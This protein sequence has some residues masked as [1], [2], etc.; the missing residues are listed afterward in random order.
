MRRILAITPNL[1]LPMLSGDSIRYNNLIVQ[2]ARRGWDVSLFSLCRERDFREAEIRVLRNVYSEI[3]VYPF[4]KAS[5]S[6]YVDLAKD[7]ILRRPFHDHLLWSADAQAIF[8]RSFS[9]HRYDVIFIHLIHMYR[10]VSGRESNVSILDTHSAEYLRL[11][12]MIDGNPRSP[13]AF[14][15]RTQ[16][17]PVKKFE[18]ETVRE[19]ACTL[20][21][22]PDELDYFGSLGARRVEL[23]ANGV[24]LDTHYPKSGVTREPRILFLGSLSYSANLDALQYLIDAILPN[25]KRADAQLDIVG[26]HPPTSLP[27]ISS[28]SPIRADAVGE[29]VDVRPY[30]DRN[31]FLV[32]PLRYGGGTRVKIIEGLAQGIPVIST[33][34]GCSGLGLQHLEEIIVVDDAKEFAD[35]IDRLLEDTELCQRLAANGRKK[36]ERDFGWSRI[37]DNLHVVIESIASGRN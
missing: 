8:D 33:S 14:Y 6:K 13:R 16:L 21:V 22:S 30:I 9:L 7:T 11:K 32:V 34:V 18:E 17:G 29:V 1:P 19:V 10:Y 5:K 2:L 37:A 27:R 25:C 35:W 20:A 36:V 28:R 26:S 24:D 3:T 4:H 12:S 31:R 15:A 23:V